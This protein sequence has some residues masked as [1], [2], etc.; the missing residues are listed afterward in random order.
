[1]GRRRSY[2]VVG[3]FVGAATKM[4][5]M[6]KYE[7]LKRFL[8]AAP[9]DEPVSLSFE[10]VS[11]LVGGLPP[12]AW[13]D[14]TWWGNTTHG[15]RSQSSSWMSAGRRV[16]ELRLGEAVVF[17]PADSFAP[18]PERSPGSE[19][20]GRP[21]I[22]DG[23]FALAAV[24]ER[25]GYSSVAA[26]VADHSCFLHPSTVA[27]TKGQPLFR[28]VRDPGQRG[29]YGTLADGTAVMFD[30]N[31]TPAHAFMWAAQRVKGADVQLNHLWGDPKNPLTYTALW[32][33][34]ATPA[35]LAKT[36]DGSNH[37]EVL[38]VLRYRAYDLY[39]HYPEREDRPKKPKGY[40]S[41]TWL[42]HTEPIAN[43]EATL[44][45]RMAAAPKNRATVVAREIG[46]LFSGWEP[47][48]EI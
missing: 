30:D 2:L 21:A 46:W 23:V 33:M 40:D 29:R 38:A 22:M 43:L 44:R 9:A 35:F 27:Q 18:P 48:T 42:E 37:P 39:G 13:T 32:N 41:L 20:R 24:L 15:S 1:M 17:S 25:A 14:R 11:R 31:S 12:S 10:E 28:T 8:D 3:S 7:P 45:A 5:R 34:C 4:K 47:D 36:T 26:A 6:A 19:P 16:T